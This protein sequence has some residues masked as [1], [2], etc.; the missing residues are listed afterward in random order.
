MK[1]KPACIL[2]NAV[3][4]MNEETKCGKISA[5]MQTKKLKALAAFRWIGSTAAIIK[6][7]LDRGGRGRRSACGSKMANATPKH[8]NC[9]Q[10]KSSARSGGRKQTATNH[11]KSTLS[12]FSTALTL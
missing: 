6:S 7:A 2:S 5:A 4:T 1:K 11:S 3:N 9:F 12:A 10:T 8:G